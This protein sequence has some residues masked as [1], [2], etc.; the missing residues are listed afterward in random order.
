MDNAGS[1]D[2]GQ[3]DIFGVDINSYSLVMFL[4]GWISDPVDS[5][6]GKAAV[7]GGKLSSRAF[8]SAQ[9]ITLRYGNRCPPTHLE[10]PD[11]RDAAG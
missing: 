5:R 1:S 4:I 11:P 3:N 7:A 9:Q 10:P 2:T 6:G 8:L